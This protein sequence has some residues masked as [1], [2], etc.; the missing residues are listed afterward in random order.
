METHEKRLNRDLIIGWSV[1]VMVLFAAYLLEVVKNERTIAYLCVFMLVTG[2]PALICAIMYRKNPLNHKLRYYIVVGYF[3]MYLF[4]MISGNTTL[5]FVY[6]LPLLSLLILYH[7]PKLIAYTGAATMVLNLYFILKR[8]EANEINSYNSK[9]VEIQIALLVL[10]FG[11]SFLASSIY[12]GI[13]KKNLEYMKMLDEKSNQIQRMT[14]Q[15]IETIANTLDA[16]DEYTQGHSRRVS[17]YAVHIAREMNMDEKEVENIKYIA[18]LHDIGK[19]GVP[20]Y[21]LN[22][23]GKLTDSEYELMKQHTVTGGEIL[24]DINLFKDLDVGAKYHHERYDGKGYP[25]GLKGEEIPLIARIICMADSYDAMTSNRV[26]RKHLSKEV[27]MSEIERCRGT[28]FDPDVADAFLRYLSKSEDSDSIA[29]KYS[30]EENIDDANKLL[31]KFMKDQTEQTIESINK[32]ELTRVYS[33]SAGER[34]ITIAMRAGQGCLFIVNLDNMRIINRQHGFRRGDYY[35]K[36]LVRVLQEAVTDI[37]ISRFGGDEFLCYIPGI[38][39]QDEIKSV[40]DNIYNKL[41]EY[42]ENDSLIEW[43][44]VSIGI[45]IH[46]KDNQELQDLQMEADKALYHVKQTT[47]N[48]YYFYRQV[49]N[50]SDDLH[51]A[52]LCNIIEALKR[53]DNFSDNTVMGEDD[54]L[55]MYQFVRDIAVTKG[56]RIRLIMFTLTD[57]N[58]NKPEGSEEIMDTVESSILGTLPD[59]SAI[60][61]YSSAQRIVLVMEDEK[62]SL[63]EIAKKIVTDFTESCGYD[64]I[65]LSYVVAEK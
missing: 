20:D 42:E 5:V 55:R 13:Q 27:V 11:G 25:N 47:K 21:V 57:A 9:D 36:Q 65:K 64:S 43:F 33:R 18:L 28:Q 31:K 59:E 60:S 40:M 54:F 16:K 37:I 14:L 61:Q 53:K 41:H 10:C 22:K 63:G 8:A 38:T 1:I 52:E 4:V 19:I 12:D 2:L 44:C 17:E 46:D 34:Y 32:D 39:K 35:L 6:I 58:G 23:P 48:N 51:K 62:R 29:V 7:Q 24:K 3:C 15:T 26:Y 49:E 45:T 30:D 50:M 56:E